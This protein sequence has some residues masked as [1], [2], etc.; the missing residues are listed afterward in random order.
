MKHH[1]SLDEARD[2]GRNY[3]LTT[4]HPTSTCS[5]LQEAKGGVVDTS[6]RVYGTQA[7]RVVDASVFPLVLQGNI[8]SLLREWPMLLG[9]SI[10]SF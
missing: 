5:M 3:T 6:C 10:D 9:P 8:V 2:I 1:E 4:W 7:L